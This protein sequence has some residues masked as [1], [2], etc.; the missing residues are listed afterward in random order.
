MKLQYRCLNK[1]EFSYGKFTIV[2]IR[3][4]DR[5]LIMK[6]RNEQ[7]YHLRQKVPL[8][9]QDQDTYFKVSIS[10]IFTQ[11]KPDQLLFSLLENKVCIGYG[12]LVHINWEDRNAEISFLMNTELEKERFEE[13]WIVFLKL[14]KTIAFKEL[15]LFKIFTFAFDLREKLYSAL[16]KQGFTQEARLKNHIFFNKKYQDVVIHALFN[17][18]I[19]LRKASICDLQ[20]TY[21]WVNNKEIRK[22]SPSQGIIS[23]NS[24]SE[25]FRSKITSCSTIY[26]IAMKQNNPIGSIRFDNQKSELVLSYLLDPKYHGQGYG[27]EL[28]RQGIKT[29]EGRFNTSKLVGIVHKENKASIHLFE[30]F[31]FQKAKNYINENYIKYH[32]YGNW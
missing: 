8:T 3:H 27:K 32:K 15:R 28:F 19:S 1:R 29:I 25:W 4:K 2:P 16:E 13:L 12:G 5:Y 30:S 11:D 23:L 10:Q 9:K 7:I 17:E 31:N 6:W 22:Y 14:I 21:R 20:T 18:P 24:H 26:L